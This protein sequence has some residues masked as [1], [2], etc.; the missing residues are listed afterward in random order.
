MSSPQKQ[1]RDLIEQLE[2][3]HG[4]V[5]AFRVNRHLVAAHEELTRK[6]LGPK[7]SVD[8]IRAVG[9]VARNLA[10]AADRTHPSIRP[11]EP[12]GSIGSG[13]AVPRHPPI[14][15]EAVA[16]LNGL[17]QEDVAQAMEQMP[18]DV[19]E[20]GV[21]FEALSHRRREDAP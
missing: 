9:A 11:P 14:S 17:S 15:H 18:T 12:S 5:S 2:R 10:S 19:L 4:I 13:Q 7:P 21:K 1:I 6:P 3:D 16:A 20:W 8:Q